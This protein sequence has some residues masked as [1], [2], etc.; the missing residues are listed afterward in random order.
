[1]EI[2]KAAVLGIVQGLTEF[3]PVSSSGHLVITPFILNWDYIPVYYT[4]LLHF[5][6]L[7]ALVTVFY[8]EIWRIIKHFFSGI[9]IA[10]YRKT[11]YFKLALFII[12]A[13]V[14]AVIAGLFLEDFVEDFFSKPL[15]VAVFLLVTSFF[16]FAGEISAKIK[17]RNLK[18]ASSSLHDFEKPL[19]PEDAALQTK[20]S[21]DKKIPGHLIAFIIGI[22][23][24]VAIFPGISRSGS[25]IS[26]AR[27]FGIKREA[28]VKFS[29]L[30]SIPVIFGAFIFEFPS[31]FKAVKTGQDFSAA[32][33]LTGFVFSYLSGLFAIKFLVKISQRRNFNFF[34]LY[35]ILLSALIFVLIFVRKI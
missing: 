1:L 15:Y 35:C 5:A 34:A 30:M 32:G 11:A 3:F 24:A 6:T 25:T 9:F 22:G 8:R 14:P 19:I 27:F 13:T 12:I 7:L 4:V 16:L 10:V 33:L 23:Q 29:L 21:A 31:V 2:L 28:C 18:N 17:E 20:G 26:F